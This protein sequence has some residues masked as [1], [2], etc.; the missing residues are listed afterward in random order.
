[1]SFQSHTVRATEAFE[2]L[3]RPHEIPNELQVTKVFDT[4]WR[5]AAERQGVFFSRLSGSPPP[6]TND[7][8]L[9]GNKFTNVYRASD[10]VSQY[11]IRNVIPW[12]RQSEEEVFFRIMLFKL[13]NRGET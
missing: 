9:G 13:F 6:W 5:F 2:G 12:G 10:R 7:D 3:V 4:F 11:L 8:I 1:M